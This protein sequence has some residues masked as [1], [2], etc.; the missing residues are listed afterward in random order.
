MVSIFDLLS[1]FR[2]NNRPDEKEITRPSCIVHSLLPRIKRA[3]DVEV[4]EELRR[5]IETTCLKP[6]RL[7]G[8]SL[9]NLTDL[10]FESG[11]MGRSDPPPSYREAVGEDREAERR[12]LLPQYQDLVVVDER[13]RKLRQRRKFM[14]ILAAFIAAC[15]MLGI[16]IKRSGSRDIDSGVERRVKVA[17]IGMCPVSPKDSNIFWD[18]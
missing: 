18:N 17:V 3:A 11:E 7:L 8:E 6:F 16:G 4:A 2:D 9:S 5:E 14:I 13:A 1:W 12:P 15:L 10:S